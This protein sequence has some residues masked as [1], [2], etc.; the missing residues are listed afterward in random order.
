MAPRRTYPHHDS[1]T[2]C[3]Y[4]IINPMKIPTFLKHISATGLLILPTL[5]FAQQVGIKSPIEA[6]NLSDLIYVIIRAVRL[7]VLPLIAIMIM[8]VGWKFIV[9]QGSPEKIK[10]A[11]KMALY[12]FVGA[13]IILS[14]EVLADI[15]G[16]T[17]DSLN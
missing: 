13:L 10:E 4:A 8:W 1:Q 15:I 12:V 3:K 5:L 11:R 14:A 2:R 7:V 16:D 9:A 17:V 6:D